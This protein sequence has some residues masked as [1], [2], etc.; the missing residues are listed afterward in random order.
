MLIIH[1]QS[2]Q[3][4]I[5]LKRSLF[6]MWDE[7]FRADI[8]QRRTRIYV[9]RSELI[10]RDIYWTFFHQTPTKLR[11]LRIRMHPIFVLFFKLLFGVVNFI[12]FV[13]MYSFKRVK[14]VQRKKSVSLKAIPCACVIYSNADAA[15]DGFCFAHLC[16]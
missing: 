1:F 13:R 4:N 12:F 11:V 5:V 14:R 10:T 7:K 2:H 9:T 8:H 6:F 3:L 16:Y 15:A